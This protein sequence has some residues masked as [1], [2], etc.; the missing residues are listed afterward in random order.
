[1][2]KRIRNLREDHDYTQREIA[3]KLNMSP[4]Q[5]QR[6]ESGSVTPPIDVIIFL[7]D[8]YNVSVDYIL[9]RTN[10]K[11]MFPKEFEDGFA[12]MKR[13]MDYLKKLNPT[14]RDIIIGSMASMVKE[15]NLIKD[16]KEK[17]IG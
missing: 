11:E 6:Y 13:Y 2:F 8:L 7:A 1:M 3:A 17:N 14:N 15:Q 16:S 12:E 4:P 10:S 5:Y 9:D